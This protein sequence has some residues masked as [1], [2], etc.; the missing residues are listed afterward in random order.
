MHCSAQH[1]GG[2]QH[3]DDSQL[4]AD[5]VEPLSR[6]GGSGDS[7]SGGM[8][9]SGG[10]RVRRR[11]AAGRNGV[12]SSNSGGGECRERRAPGGGRNRGRDDTDRADWAEGRGPGRR[13]ERRAS[14]RVRDDGD[15]VRAE[16]G[17]ARGA[18][19]GAG[20]YATTRRGTG[21]QGA[22]ST[23]ASASVERPARRLPL[24]PALPVVRAND[25]DKGTF[26]HGSTF[27]AVGAST[28]VVVALRELGITRPS[29]VQAEAYKLLLGKE[30][31]RRHVAIMDQAGSGKT[32]AYLLPLMQ[33]LRAE[34]EA[35]D[36]PRTLAAP[37]CP[38]LVVI[39][40]TT[41][42]AQQVSPA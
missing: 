27:K 24:L 4:I 10:V 26:F 17:E 28:E 6:D 15:H 29:H 41:E 1:D 20:A 9:A 13:E 18:P 38:R 34:E 5:A 8:G 42:L 37:R 11:S 7:S 33:Q 35:S 21:G 16:P 25:V 2:K 39:A 31:R 30:S 12:G 23:G 3:P 19:S 22:G 36:A 14:G 40:P 32:L